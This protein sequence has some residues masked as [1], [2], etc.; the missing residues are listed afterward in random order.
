MFVINFKLNFKKI[1]II[2]CLLGLAIATIVEFSNMGTASVNSKKDSAYDFLITEN[3]WCDALK[4]IHENIDENVNKTVKIKG[5]VFRMPDFKENYF[6]CGR[7]VVSGSED[8]VAGILC[9]FDDSKK[10]LDNE[11]VEVT[12]II[13]KCD[14]NGS[15]PSIKVGSIEKVTAPTNTFVEN[16]TT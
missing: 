10:L 2:C 1:L 15:Q 4:N 6:V 14:Y 13:T 12:G 11:W 16:K 5:F 3:N 7:Y 8:M 9:E